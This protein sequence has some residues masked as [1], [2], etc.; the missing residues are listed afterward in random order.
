[1]KLAEALVLRA[2]IQKR[3]AQVKSRL[4]RN[5]KVQEGEKPAEDPTALLREY[6]ALTAELIQLIRRINVTNSASSVAGRG[7]TEALAMRDVLKL[8]HATYRDLADAAST[9]QFATTRSEIRLRAAVSVPEIQQRAD[10][11]ARELRELDSRIQEA[12]WQLELSD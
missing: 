3:I 6:D 1:M 2:D 12:N 4:L 9:S 5:A 10:A 8:R 11:I 7:M